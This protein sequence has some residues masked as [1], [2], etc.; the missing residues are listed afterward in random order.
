M[1][2]WIAAGAVAVVLALGGWWAFGRAAPPDAAAY[3]TASVE[4][5]DV[6][7]TVSA[8][9]RLQARVTVEV[10][11]Q[12]SGQ[13]LEINA[14]FNDV[15]TA[16]QPIA[17]LD[18]ATFEQRLRQAEADLAVQRANARAAEAQ[19]AQAEADAAVARR[20]L[21]RIAP[22][23]ERGVA[24]AASL[25]AATAAATRSAASVAAAAAQ[26]DVAAARVMQAEAAVANAAVDLERTTIRSPVDGVVVARSVDVGQTV[27]AS[28]QAPVLFTIAQDLALMQIEIEVDEADIGAVRPGQRI[29]FNVDAYPDR[30]FSGAVDEV[31]KQPNIVSNVV[32]YVVTAETENPA[33]ALLPGM[34]ANVE[35]IVEERRDVIRAPN[36]ALRFTPADGVET[37]SADGDG[38]RPRPRGRRGGG[39]GGG[40]PGGGGGM[41]D[42]LAEQLELTDDQRAHA[43]GVFEAMRGR[44]RAMFAEAQAGGGDRAAMRERM[45]AMTQAAL[46][47][48]ATV[49]TPDQRARLAEL[50]AEMAGARSRRGVVWT[51]RDDGALV[52]HAVE[53]GASDTRFTELVTT[54]LEPGAAVVIGGGPAPAAS[55]GQRPRGGRPF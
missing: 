9:G 38:E 27:A 50:R 33:G 11:S 49:L 18:P 40:G 5:G 32:T 43:Q 44:M 8:T 30:E 42:R 48:V 10:G 35:I 47:D 41:L 54:T 28:L 19:A 24:S 53:I 51:E 37:V 3:R 20:D 26:R 34:T 17:R 1:Q 6:L 15:V 29:T 46:D 13:L 21:D 7:R 16:D 25:D 39:G 31:R 12:L 2:R 14:D 22:L 52:R 55:S 23:A 4:R 45:Q 36:A